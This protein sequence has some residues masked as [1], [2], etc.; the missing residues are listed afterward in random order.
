MSVYRIIRYT[1]KSTYV[2]NNGLDRDC[3]ATINVA[4]TL[5][6]ADIIVYWIGFTFWGGEE[7]IAVS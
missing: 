6:I 3:A 4:I 2:T 1:Y 5:K 7:R